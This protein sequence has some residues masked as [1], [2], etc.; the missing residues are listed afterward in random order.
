MRK[1]ALLFVSSWLVAA[2]VAQATDSTWVPPAGRN[3][4]RDELTLLVGYHQG[5]YGNVELGFGRSIYGVV[6]HPFGFTYYAGAELRPDRPQLVG[7]KIGTYVT[8]GGAMGLQ[9][10]RYQEGSNG[11]TVL[12]PEI[13]IGIW[14]AR[15]T[16]AYNINLSSERLDG[17]NTHMLSIHYAFRLARVKNDQVR[18]AR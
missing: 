5:R 17:T 8:F 16:Y 1:V 6:H 14:K 2:C 10:V 7:W 3:W 12:R 18:R 9:L 11:C 15:V 4:K 13:G